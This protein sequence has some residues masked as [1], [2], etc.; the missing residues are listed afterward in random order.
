MHHRGAGVRGFEPLRAHNSSPTAA[1]AG[2]QYF[3][4]SMHH[5]G[6]GVRGFEPLRAHNSSPTAANAGRQFSFLIRAPSR[7]RGSRAAPRPQ[8]T[9]HCR[10]C[11]AA[12]LF[13]IR[14]PSRCRGSRV[15]SPAECNS[16][17]P[18]FIPHCR[19]RRA[20]VL[21]PIRVPSRCRK[22]IHNQFMSGKIIRTPQGVLLLDREHQI[23]KNRVNHPIMLKDIP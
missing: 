18:Q 5:R 20:A 1:N 22:P 13:P 10:Q 12:V 19:Q 23:W 15:L 2:R 17:C 7:C 6:A 11:R 21:F 3:F 14:A 16:A 4:P 9:P 8:F